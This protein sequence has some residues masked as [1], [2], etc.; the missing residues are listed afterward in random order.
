M[1]FS[2]CPRDFMAPEWVAIAEC[3][4][5]IP[6][7][8]KLAVDVVPFRLVSFCLTIGIRLIARNQSPF[9][10]RTHRTYLTEIDSRHL[11]A[12]AILRSIISQ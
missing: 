6:S 12:L 9:S 2:D 3:A 11:K 5:Q 10:A 8:S 4:L 1:F 7:M